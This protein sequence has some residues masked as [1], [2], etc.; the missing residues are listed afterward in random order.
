M[1]WANQDYAQSGL[2]GEATCNPYKLLWDADFESVTPVKAAGWFHD[3][4]YLQIAVYISFIT[5][6]FRNVCCVL[7]PM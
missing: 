6:I 2:S 1:I 4:G 7:Q 5:V 3:C